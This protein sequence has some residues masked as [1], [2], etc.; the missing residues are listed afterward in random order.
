MS[1][2]GPSGTSV[3]HA[4]RLLKKG[5]LIA[6]PTETV[7]GLAANAFKPEAV[8]AIYTAKGRPSNNPLILHTDHPERLSDWGMCLPPLAQRLAEEFAPGPLTFVIRASD[9]ILP[10]VNGGQEG[11]AVRFP[12]HPLT[13]EL[14]RNLDF[15]L[16]APSANPSGYMSPTRAQHVLDGLGDKI[17]YVLDG[18]PCAIG[19]EST[20]V[21]FLGEVPVLLRHGG[22]PLELLEQRIGPIELHPSLLQTTAPADESLLREAPGM[23]SRHYAPHCPLLVGDPLEISKAFPGERLACIFFTKPEFVLSDLCWVLSP[24]GQTGEA[25][26]NLFQV[27]REAEQTHPDKILITPFPD[28]GLG[29]ALNDRLRR[30]A[31]EFIGANPHGSASPAVPLSPRPAEAVTVASPAAKAHQG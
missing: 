14:L 12:A 6:I 1:T 18:G 25:A 24:S 16:V 20:I 8:R 17:D 11:V 4:A 22:L 15:P 3:E 13:L 2:T 21:S 28:E 9:R 5:R 29:R 19:L 30:A 27:L 23:F 7:Y 31:F 26:R 10:E